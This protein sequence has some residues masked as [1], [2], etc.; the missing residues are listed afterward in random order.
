MKGEHQQ[1]MKV[2]LG[3]PQ[4]TA[5]N[6]LVNSLI[7]SMACQLGS[8]ICYQCSKP[9][10][11]ALTM[12]F[13]HKK[14]WLHEPNAKELFHDLDNIA[15]SHRKCNRPRK[16]LIGKKLRKEYPEGTRR[17]YKCQRLLLESKFPKDSRRWHGFDARCKDCFNQARRENRHAGEV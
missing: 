7:F 4:G 1:E 16:E 17:C 14:P 10:T 11:S 8:S 5:R 6:K 2:Q 13:E 3:E 15:F 9:I 12:S